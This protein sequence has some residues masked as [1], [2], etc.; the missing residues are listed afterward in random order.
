MQALSACPITTEESIVTRRVSFVEK[1]ASQETA[2]VVKNP[3]PASTQVYA[4]QYHCV[5]RGAQSV[6][7]LHTVL[8]SDILQKI[9]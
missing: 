9:A 1:L 5:Q 6:V 8:T 4:Q 2:R 3:G 7:F